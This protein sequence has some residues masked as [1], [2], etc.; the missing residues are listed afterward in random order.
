VIRLLKEIILGPLTTKLK[1]EAKWRDQ[2][3][4]WQVYADECER[5]LQ[6]LRDQGE[7]QRFW[8]RLRS[9]Q[10][11]RDE[12]LNE[13]RVANHLDSLGY[14]IVA[15]EP[16]DDPAHSVEFSISLGRR[17]AA[18]IEVK[19][20]GWEAELTPEERRSGR[21]QKDKYIGIEARAA[22]PIQVIRQTIQKAQPKFT[23]KAPSLIF[24]S[25]DCFVSVGEWGWGPL[26]MAL[27]QSSLGWG[28]GLFRDPL[29]SNVGGVCLF[30]IS[31]VT[32]QNGIQWGSLCMTNPNA[33]PTATLPKELVTQLST[34][35][36]EPTN[37]KIQ[38]NSRAR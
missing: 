18:F 16:I 5:L 19:S 38:Q 28:D 37:S 24:I 12:A 23:G 1:A 6:F 31:R 34:R 15:W 29:Y 17:D 9:K 35:S 32:D 27:T 4:A 13:I 21:T 22:S 36:I 7:T 30:W 3:P 25:D 10:Q 11:Q 8:P 14:P 2:Y 33:M 20:P 26:Q